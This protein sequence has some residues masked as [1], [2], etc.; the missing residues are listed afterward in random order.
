MTNCRRMPKECRSSNDQRLRH[1]GGTARLDIF[2]CRWSLVRHSVIRHSSF[3]LLWIF[4][5]SAAAKENIGVL[6]AKPRWDVL[7]NYQ[8]TIT[9]DEFAHLIND[10]YCTHGIPA[11]LIKIDNDAAQIVTDRDSHKAFTL[12]FAADPDSKARIPRLWRPA[13]SLPPA[14]ANRPLA[15]LRIALD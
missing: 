4:A 3:F 12:A 1:D 14:K 9:H 7:E 15:G 2:V 13:K 5:I 10:V 11:A 6:G 8:R